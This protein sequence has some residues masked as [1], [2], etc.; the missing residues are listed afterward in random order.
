MC[1]VQKTFPFSRA[2]PA[3][4]VASRAP[5]ARRGYTSHLSPE[6]E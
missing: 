4:R 5:L 1:L 6:E 2:A 3:E